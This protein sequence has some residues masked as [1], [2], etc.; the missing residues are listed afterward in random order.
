MYFFGMAVFR[1]FCA[2]DTANRDKPVLAYEVSYIKRKI[3]IYAQKLK[4]PLGFQFLGVIPYFILCC[5]AVIL[6]YNN[7]K[8][9]LTIYVHNFTRPDL[10]QKTI[11]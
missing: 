3:D 5:A 2:L 4:P 6:L 1:E 11:I 8:Q 7:C 9:Q 10:F